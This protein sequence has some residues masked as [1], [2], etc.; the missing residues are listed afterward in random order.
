MLQLDPRLPDA[1]DRLDMRIRYRGHTLDLALTREA[2]TVHGRDVPR[3]AHQSWGSETREYV[4]PGG[5]R[6]TFDL[7]A[8][9]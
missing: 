3:R 9:A 7:G 1:L 6:T 4:L 8:R 2:L 5:G